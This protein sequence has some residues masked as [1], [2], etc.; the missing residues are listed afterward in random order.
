[1]SEEDDTDFRNCAFHN[2]QQQKQY[3][4][5]NV[6]VY[7]NGKQVG[8]K[9]EKEGTGRENEERRKGIG[10]K[11][12]REKSKIPAPDSGRGRVRGK[13]FGAMV[14]ENMHW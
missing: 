5:K 10:G 9:R 11:R 12:E 3:P 13:K 1:M 4:I 8:K 14:A 7:T 2:R 6:Q